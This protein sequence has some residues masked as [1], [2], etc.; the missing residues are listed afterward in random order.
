MLKLMVW[1]K[2]G[3]KNKKYRKLRETNNIRVIMSTSKTLIHIKQFK[4]PAIRSTAYVQ[5]ELKRTTEEVNECQEKI[6]NDDDDDVK[7]R[8]KQ[9]R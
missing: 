7:K 2:A 6:N 8:I 5:R 9:P 1:L 3:K 4:Q